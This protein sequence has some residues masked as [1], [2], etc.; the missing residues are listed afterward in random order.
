[1]R[2][3]RQAFLTG[4]GI[5]IHNLVL[6]QSK[7]LILGG[8]TFEE[9]Y[10]IEAH[11]DGDLIYHAIANAIL[12]SLGLDDIGT[13]F[14]DEDLEN[15]NRNSKVILDFALNKM[16]EFNYEINNLDLTIICEQINFVYKKQKII[17][18]LR[19]DLGISIIGLKATRPEN[20]E[21]MKI[22]CYAQILLK[23]DL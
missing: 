21:N 15:K 23:D 3:K 8:L 2:N 16:R 18:K 4:L 1:M 5:D 7:P 17:D 19:E 12:G 11:S 13:Y 10:E 22:Q 14:S 20:K 6:K 9:K